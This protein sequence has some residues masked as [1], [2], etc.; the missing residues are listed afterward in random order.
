MRWDKDYVKEAADSEKVIPGFNVFGYE[1]AQAVVRAAETAGC[2][3]LLMVNKGA[4]DTM[5]VECWGNLLSAIAQ[6]S[7]VPV[8][9][10]L[11]HCTDEELIRR[12]IDSGFTSVMYDGSKLPFEKNREVTQRMAE[13]AHMHKVLL[14]GELGQVPYSDLGE[15]QIRFTSP[16]EAARM[17]VETEVDWLAVS[18]GNV[19]RLVNR[20][21]AI[22]FSVLRK[23]QKVCQLPLVIHGSS[24]ISGEDMKGLKKEHIGKMNFGTVLRKAFSDA[25]RQEMQ[26][27]PEEFDRLK[28]FQYPANQVE[29]EAYQIICMLQKEEK[30]EDS[31]K[32]A[33]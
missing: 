16:E 7:Q 13:Y 21:V 3:V 27:H 29:Q 18:I 4:V 20:T 10:H 24:G 25:L 22:D 14:E 32:R 23:I 1:D 30:N 2:P 17:P 19:H 15:T 28:L 5:D 8:G 31:A 6:R 33:I 26:K 11:D 12:A 9:V